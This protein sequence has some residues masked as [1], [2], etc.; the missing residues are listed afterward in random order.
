MGNDDTA[1]SAADVSLGNELGRKQVTT[2]SSGVPAGATTTGVYLSPSEA[3]GP[4]E[5]LGW[6]FN[7]GNQTGSGTLFARVLYSDSKVAGEESYD[8]ER[9]DTQT[10]QP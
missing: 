2:S 3:N 9:I 6:F 4:V 1:P 7:G 8:V 10:R 5:E